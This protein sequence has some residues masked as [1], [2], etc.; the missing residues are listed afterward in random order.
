MLLV[1]NV[2]NLDGKIIDIT[3]ESETSTLLDVEG[4]L[5]LMPAL[6]DPHVHFRVPGAEHKED[7]ISAARAAISGGITRVFDMPNNYPP[8]VDQKSLYEKIEL[9]EKQLKEADIPLRYNLYLG[10]DANHLEEIG[11]L[12]KSIIGLK[13]YMGSS[14][15]GLVMDDRKSL[16]R[17]F[18]IAAQENVIVAVHAESEMLIRQNKEKIG[19]GDPKNHSLIRS[20][21]VAVEATKEAI[22]LAEKYGTQLVIC[23]VSTKEELDL[24]KQAKERELLVYCEISPHHLFLN[25][26]LYD[27]IG[28]RALVNP[29]IRDISH[30]NALWRGIDNNIVDF[31]GTDHA[32]HTFD[33]K[34]Q[35]YGKAPS[36]FPGIETLLPLLLNAYNEKKITLDKIIA[37]TKTNIEEIFRIQRNHDFVLVDLEL[38]KKVNIS[39]L[40]SKCRWS[41]YE[42]MLLKGWPIYTIL[43]G[44]VFPCF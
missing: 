32:P 22:E 30:C 36:G 17:A 12:K 20:P 8:C 9:I 35:E 40:K 19:L 4:K 7:W 44:R 16:D 21:E 10:A 1:K 33:E 27:K 37:L 31:I 23:H 26:E 18:Q 25:E 39:E 24:I 13:I 6:I 14:T 28:T 3:I 29:P 15:G 42:G 2:K 41:P 5:T 38:E 43:K 11:K 34:N